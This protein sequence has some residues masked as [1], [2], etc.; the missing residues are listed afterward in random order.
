M[1][2][3]EN[4]IGVIRDKIENIYK[5]LHRHKEYLNRLNVFPVPDGDTGFNMTLT[6]QGALANMKDYK[7]ESISTG[8]YLKNFAEQMLMN[9]RGCSG[10]ILSL[11]CQGIS[12][13]IVNNDFSKKNIFKAFENGYKNAYEGTENPREGTILTLMREFYKK[14]GELMNDNDDPVIIIKKCI[15]YLKEVLKKTPDMLPVLKQAGVVDSGGAGFLIILQGINKELKYN[16]ITIKSLPASIILNL[17]DTIKK[18]LN[19]KLSNSTKKSFVGL[20][21]HSSVDKIS[22]IKLRKIIQESKHLINNIEIN[23][24]QLLHK[25]VIIDD[26]EN[27]ENS[28]NPKIKQRYCTEFIL[29]TNQISSKE[30]IKDIIGKYGD[31]LIILNSGNKYKVHIHTNKPE[32]VFKDVSKYGELVFTKVDDMKKQHRNFIS[33]DTID[34]NREKSIFCIVSGEG[35][36][37]ILKELGADD[38]LC[39]GK[40]KPSVKQLV[41]ELNKLRTKNIIVAADDKDILMGLKYA[42]SLSKSNVNIVESNNVISLISMMMSISKEL[43]I[44][45]I[46]DS[47]MN[48]LNNIRFCGIAKAVRNTTTKDG[49]K[50]NKNDYFAIYNREIILSDKNIEQLINDTIK[51]LIKGES[52]ITIYKGIPAKKEKS[53]IPKLKNSFP[54]FEFEEYYGG[55]YQYHY[56]LTF[57]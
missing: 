43:D 22:N 4:K 36:G 3:T 47:I 56:Y 34:Y 13:V 7:K 28:W 40:N 31:S 48:S 10:V 42:A 18:L 57:E 2:Q 9:S 20:L 39:Y 21:L 29:E 25:K 38:V 11:Y 54:E 52:L 53:I 14:Y 15:P 23:A 32:S 41:K 12:Q 37:K 27:M 35:F 19:N 33:A 26:L 17:N 46:F 50:V 30:Q 6:I 1:I 44:T 55:Q 8:E 16:E 45:T 24:T 49:K 51:K 5:Y